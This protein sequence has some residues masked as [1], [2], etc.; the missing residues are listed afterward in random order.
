MTG[1]DAPMPEYVFHNDS[2][3]VR[4]WILKL[5]RFS[6]TLVVAIAV[7]ASWHSYELIAKFLAVVL[8]ANVLFVPTLIRLKE[9]RGGKKMENSVFEQN[10]YMQLAMLAMLMARLFTRNH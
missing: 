2:H 1:I 9:K 4:P 6:T 5:S 7:I 8:L 10:G 3:S